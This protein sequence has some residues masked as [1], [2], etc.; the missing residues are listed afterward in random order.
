MFPDALINTQRIVESQYPSYCGAS[1]CRA[2][3]K[4]ERLRDA[5]KKAGYSSAAEAARALDMTVSTFVSH[6]NGT[7]DFNEQDAARYARKFRVSVEWLF[8]GSGDASFKLRQDAMPVVGEVRAGAWLEIDGEPTPDEY[9]P[10]TSDPAWGHAPQFALKVVGTSMN[11]V[12]TPG[13][14][15]VVASWPE[16]GAELRENDLVVVRRERAMTYEVTL[17]MAK[18]GVERMGALAGIDRSEMAGTDSAGRPRRR[19]SGHNRRQGHREIR[20]AVIALAL[21][22]PLL[23][24][25]GKLTY[26]RIQPTPSF[27]EETKT[28]VIPWDVEKSTS[29]ID[30]SENVLIKRMATDFFY[31]RFNNQKT[32]GLYVYCREQRTDFF[33][34]FEDQFMADSGGYGEVTLRL[35]KEKARRVEMLAST[36]HSA[37]GLWGGRGVAFLKS[38]IG[39]KQLLL[40]AT[41]FHESNIEVTF[42]LTGYP[43]ALAEVRKACKW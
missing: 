36:D 4:H 14:Y 19:H 41:P 7:R 24:G 5:W 27:S 15:V 25:A 3:E 16:L 37:L 21:C 29:K 18:Q 6:Q 43:E 34:V 20:T 40:V 30:D 8:F 26:E 12:S 38:T 35:D 28:A 23:M 9:L 32:V 33:F 11:K 31:D 39:K 1:Q 13:S 17:K 10:I 42:D 22:S 2:M